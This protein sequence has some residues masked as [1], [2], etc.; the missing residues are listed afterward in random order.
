MYLHQTVAR[1]SDGRLARFDDLPAFLA[2]DPGERETFD[3][4]RV[5]FH[6]PIF[7]ARA[8][9][10]GT[11]RDFLEVLLPRLP[12]EV[13]LEVETYSWNVL[14]ADLRTETVGESIVRELDWARRA[15]EPG[16]RS[17]GG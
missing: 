10:C 3:E 7:A 1:R 8:R 12:D 17:S 16:P 5:H 6:V 15:R 2:L 11:T 14:P 13:L 9:G 4:C